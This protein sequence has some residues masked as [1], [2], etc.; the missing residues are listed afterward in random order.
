MKLLI[1]T[2]NNNGIYSK[3]SEHFGH[4]LYF[5]IYETN[6]KKLKFVENIIDHSNTALTPVAQIMK[7]NPNIVF[8]LGIGKR[9]LNLFDEKGVIVK[10]GNFKT[11]KEIISNF[12]Q[13]I[14]LTNGCNH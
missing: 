10:T 9:A 2:N 7:L 5:A 4:C 14:D 12:N 8:S 1:A 6:T 3:L 11:I 13:L